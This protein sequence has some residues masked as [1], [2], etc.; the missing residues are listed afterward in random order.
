V[1]FK[2]YFVQYAKWSV[3]GSECGLILRHFAAFGRA[4]VKHKISP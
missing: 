2:K 3:D 1:T 4:E